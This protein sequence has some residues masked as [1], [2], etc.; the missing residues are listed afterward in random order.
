MK[1]STK[2]ALYIG[3]GVA[4]GILILQALSKDSGG[5]KRTDSGVYEGWNWKG[6]RR[7]AK[8]DWAVKVEKIGTGSGLVTVTHVDKREQ[9]WPAAQA[10]IDKQE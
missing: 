9:V 2:D 7:P 5:K 1:Q 6:V 8:K 4:A 3:G 10:Y